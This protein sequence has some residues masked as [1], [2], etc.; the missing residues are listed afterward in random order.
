MQAVVAQPVVPSAVSE[1]EEEDLRGGSQMGR[2]Q[3]SRVLSVGGL[4]VHTIAPTYKH[5][6]ARM[7][8][9]FEGSPARVCTAIISV[10]QLDTFALMRFKT[11]WVSVQFPHQAASL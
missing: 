9:P 4:T 2:R 11:V 6:C 5:T 1:Q 10:A 8:C 7:F 3:D